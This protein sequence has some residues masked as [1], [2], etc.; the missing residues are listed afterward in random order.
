MKFTTKMFQSGNNT[1]VPV[2]AEVVESLGGGRRPAVTVTVNGYAYRSTI[3]LMGGQFL[4]P[5]S[6]DKRRAA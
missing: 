2:P 1:G 5:F 4:I 6:A 3:A